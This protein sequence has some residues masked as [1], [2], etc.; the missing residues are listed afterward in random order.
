MTYPFVPATG[1]H[2][3]RRGAIV[4]IVLHTTESDIDPTRLPDRGA[5]QTAQ[6][7]AHQRGVSSHY[8]VDDDSIIQCVQESDESYTQA[9]WNAYCISVEQEARAGFSRDEWQSHHDGVLSNTAALIAEL[10]VR[11]NIALRAVTGPDIVDHITTFGT[12]GPTGVTTHYE[13]NQASRALGMD[14]FVGRG[15]L[16]SNYGHWTALTSHYDPGAGFPIDVVLDRARALLGGPSTPTTQDG[17]MLVLHAPVRDDGAGCYARF[18]GEM[19]PAPNGNLVG[20]PMYWIEDS[21][22][23]EVYKSWGVPERPIKLNELGNVPLLGPVP[24][25]DTLYDW[26]QFKFIRL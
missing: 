12:P 21:N 24:H 7:F 8:V 19:I 4:W 5:E 9:P 13:L 3:G 11:R 23:A 6:Y 2:R 20:M 15:M 14:W 25:D 1:F 17:K 22:L 26:S 18:F 16:G 10:N